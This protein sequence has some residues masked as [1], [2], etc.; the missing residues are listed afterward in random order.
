MNRIYLI[1]IVLV[2]SL[3]I[4]SCE[5]TL[6]EE[7]VTG[8]LTEE[9]IDQNIEEISR[10]LAYAVDQNT[11]LVKEIE[12]EIGY[13]FDYDNDA[14]IRTFL[15]REINGDKFENI[16]SKSSN[17]KY[18]SKDVEKMILESGYL[19]FSFP[20]NYKRL[21]YS[22][23][24]PLSVPI[25][26][27]INEEGIEYLEAFDNNGSSVKLSAK[28]LP[29]VPV[30]VVSRSERVDKDGLLL[31]NERSIVIP[32]EQRIYYLEAINMAK[33]NLKSGKVAKH[34]VT[35]VSEEEFY[36]QES[37]DNFN[38][39][40]ATNLKSAT[41]EDYTDLQLYAT[42]VNPN[43][44]QLSWVGYSDSRYT[45]NRY[46]IY[47]GSTLI[48]DQKYAR[49]YW[50]N[51][52][53]SNIEYTYR[54]EYYY[55]DT[56]LDETNLFQIHA[57]QRKSGGYEYI[58]RIEATSTMVVQ[59][60]GW[61]VNALEIEFDVYSAKSDGTVISHGL[62]KG[63]PIY[64]VGSGATDRY[65]DTEENKD[66]YSILEIMQW[67]RDDE[68]LKYT[69]AFRESDGGT[70]TKKD[71]IYLGLTALTVET[72][73]PDTKKVVEKAQ[74]LIE[75]LITVLRKDDH[76]GEAYINWWTD[77][78]YKQNLNPFGFKVILNHSEDLSFQN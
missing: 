55:N 73:W 35:I 64:T 51:D 43:Q 3:L 23:D 11:E 63:G 6:N 24:L 65:V 76:I 49:A 37:D 1:C 66:E 21:D 7:A 68:S 62:K 46:K 50:D 71:T 4:T 32:K 12:K 22:S 56:Y 54:V 41:A 34:I 33:N 8:A 57:S 44:I 70:N 74:P 42:T 67:N 9:Q 40:S 31:V 60:E 36:M 2:M 52:V 30:I 13:R 47:R 53:S 17:G 29:N 18:S 20:Q 14:L 77:D 16:L 10:M 39:E 58:E 61:W 69:V 59:L 38:G 5:D 26:S 45:A 27:Y 78:N 25:F 28:E 75:K 19:Q 48:K 72:I 15:G